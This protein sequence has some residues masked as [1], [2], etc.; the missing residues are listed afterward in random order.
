MRG[1][2]DSG[3]SYVITTT[4]DGQHGD[5]LRDSVLTLYS[6]DGTTVLMMND[7]YDGL[8]SQIS[9][10]APS[11]RCLGQPHLSHGASGSCTHFLMVSAPLLAVPC[12]SRPGTYEHL[13]TRAA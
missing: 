3:V 9:W 6:A 8:A 11:T 5:G 1:L 2:H 7:D 13:I 12:T 10:T 4:L